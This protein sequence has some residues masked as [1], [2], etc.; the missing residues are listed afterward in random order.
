MHGAPGKLSAQR[1]RDLEPPLCQGLGNLP[2]F[3]GLGPGCRSGTCASSDPEHN[4][5]RSKQMKCQVEVEV[6]DPTPSGESA[7]VI[8][9]CL[10]ARQA[11]RDK[12]RFREACKV[13]TG[14]KPLGQVV[15][16]I[17]ERMTE[18][19]KFLVENCHDSRLRWMD[20]HVIQTIVTMN[21]RR[22]GIIRDI[23]R[24]PLHQ[25]LHRRAPR[26]GTALLFYK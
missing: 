11:L 16:Q 14:R 15:S 8:D 1:T 20:D 13:S 2:K 25:P 6:L 22:R 7:V 5:R 18:G 21:D 19:R 10:L 24:K 26:S 17:C 9:V 12:I 4:A 23:L 3:R